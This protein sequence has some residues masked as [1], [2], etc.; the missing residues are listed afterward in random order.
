MQRRGCHP[1]RLARGTVAAG[2]GQRRQM[3]EPLELVAVDAEQL[4]APGAAIGAEP[5]AVEREP[6]QRALDLLSLIHI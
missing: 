1:P 3:A 5:E 2:R 4:A 6:E